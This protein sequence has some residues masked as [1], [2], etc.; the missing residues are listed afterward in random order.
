MPILPI[1]GRVYFEGAEPLESDPFV[2]MHVHRRESILRLSHGRGSRPF[3]GSTNLE[4][5][6]MAIPIPLRVIAEPNERDACAII[7]KTDKWPAT[8]LL[9]GRETVPPL[10]CGH[11]G[12]VLVTGIRPERF[13]TREHV[14]AVAGEAYPFVDLPSRTPVTTINFEADWFL[15]G[16]SPRSRI[17]LICPA[18]GDYN[19]TGQSTIA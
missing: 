5:A 9:A 14:A 6:P 15:T 18:C 17:V 11:C 12:Q 8:P 19:E 4:E 13:A 2:S 1:A 3:G 10:C 16:A 7:V